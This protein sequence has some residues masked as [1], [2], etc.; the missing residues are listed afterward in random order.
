MSRP[1]KTDLIIDLNW[2]MMSRLHITGGFEES[3]TDVQK[4]AAADD[5]K[6]L[7]S[8]SISNCLNRLPVD[9]IVVV[10][11]GGSWRKDLPIP[12]QLNITYKGNRKESRD[13]SPKDWNFI[14]K[15][16]AEYADRL[17]SLGITVS[18]HFNIEGDDWAWYWSRRL[19]KAGKNAIVWTSDCDLKQLVQVDNETNCFTIWYNDRTGLCLPEECEFPEDPMDMFLNPPYNSP[20]LEKAIKSI[21]KKEVIRPD[22]IVINKVLCGDSGDNIKSVIRYEKG[23]RTYRFSEKDYKEICKNLD[24]KTLTEFRE[25]HRE[26]ASYIA[27]GKKWKEYGFK[28]KD[29]I[30]MLEYNTKLVW[31]NEETVPATVLTAMNNQEYKEIDITDIKNNYK[32]LL[33]NE[34]IRDIYEEIF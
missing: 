1:Y 31:I 12:D 26:I 24:I 8:R 21:V 18:Q 5:L 2:L 16:F 4:R 11:D 23:K 17:K 6:E 32:Q 28:N 29:I 19:N 33:E 30:E 13:K 27:E 14:Y 22:D 10:V 34:Q 3:K 15:V 20:I 7:V 25:L 9:N